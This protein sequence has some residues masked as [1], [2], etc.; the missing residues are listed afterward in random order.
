MTESSDPTGED[1]DLKRVKIEDELP[2]KAVGV[3]NLREKSNHF[4]LPPQDYLYVW[5]AR[6]P[7]PAARLSVLA[8]VLPDSTSDDKLLN[9]MQIG[10]KKELDVPISD[11]VESKMISE[12]EREGSKAEHYGYKKPFKQSPSEKEINEL[13]ETLRNH[14][15]GEVPTIL[16]A[17]AGGGSIPFESLRYNLPTKANEL[18]PIPTLILKS[19]IEYAPKYRSLEDEVREYGRMINNI[20]SSKLEKYF[21]VDS[22]NRHTSHCI[23]TYTTSCDSCGFDMP[24]APKWWIKKSSSSEG[25]AIKPHIVNNDIEYRCVN[26]PEDITKNEFNPSNGPVSRGGNTE[27]V[28]CGIIHENEDIKEKFRQGS[29]DYEPIAVKYVDEEGNQ[30]FRAVNEKDRIA[31]NRA[32]EKINSDLELLTL[33]STGV[34]DGFNT[35]QPKPYGIDEWRDMFTPRQLLTH[36]IYLESFN[37]VKCEIEESEKSEAVLTL[38]ALAITKLIDRNSRLAPWDSSGGRPSH[39]FEDK[40]YAFKRIFFENNMT[41]GGMDFESS[42]NRIIKSYEEIVSYTS[43]ESIDNSV[44]N[45]DAANLPFEDESI[46]AVSIDPPYY[47]SIMYSELSDIFYIWLR[48]YLD[49][50]HSDLFKNKLTNKTDEAVANPSQFESREDKSSK[51]LAKKHYKEKMSNIFSE[52]YRVLEPGGVMTVMFTHKETDAWDTLTMSLINSGFVITST[53]P[54]TSEMPQRAAANSKKSADSTILIT[55]RKP[56]SKSNKKSDTLWS[57]VKPEF[58]DVAR[59]KAEELLD[60]DLN[61]TK[62]DLIISTFGPTLRA[63]TEK[64]PVV[65]DQDNSVSPEKALKEARKSVTNTLSERYLKNSNEFDELTGVTKWYILSWLVYEQDTIPYDEGRQLGVG[66]GEYIDD[67]KSSTKIWRTKSG[68]IQLQPSDKRVQNIAKVED[69]SQS[70]S[71]RKYPVDPTSD[72][73]DYTIDAVHAALQVYDVK[74][75]QYTWNWLQEK[76]FDKDEEFKTT[77]QALLQVL[78][79]DHPD[80][81]IGKNLVAGKTGDLLDIDTSG[82]F[83]D[84]DDYQSKIDDEF[85]NEDEDS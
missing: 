78:P 30:G 47:D 79:N 59:N 67:I 83:T 32:K 11:Y 82:L 53:H 57:E 35:S 25:I 9:L 48:K 5:F 16:D 58:K 52:M 24:L 7:T 50:V 39:I 34:P 19:L 31:M 15:D 26:L 13:H 68:D 62:T 10:P 69:E 43:D 66:V 85:E 20:A 56:I 49:N 74:G 21:P 54:I 17:T 80:T 33:L 45:G 23:C 61:L 29:F 71:G 8:S 46:Q 1:D 81:E 41:V 12:D 60:S 28:N 76:D 63:F 51:K 75:S 77:L 4:D 55:G 40:N 6:R 18:N 14:W 22:N 37:E 38:L 64:Y 27:C 65:D 42:L 2:L 36:Q 3:E 70:V 72:S 73:F 44:T 84:S